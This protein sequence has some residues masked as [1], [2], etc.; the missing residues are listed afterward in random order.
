MSE[1]WTH[2]SFLLLIN[3]DKYSIFG[4]VYKQVPIDKG[5]V[6]NLHPESLPTKTQAASDMMEKV[7]IC[8]CGCGKQLEKHSPN[9]R[10]DT[11]R[12]LQDIND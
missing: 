8:K 2:G 7:A 4:D 6:M 5:G 11:H 12:G 3:L 1:T 9:D 10:D